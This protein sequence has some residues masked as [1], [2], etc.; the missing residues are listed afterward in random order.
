MKKNSKQSLGIKYN[1]LSK[2]YLK[3]SYITKRRKKM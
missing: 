3:F 1:F 2:L